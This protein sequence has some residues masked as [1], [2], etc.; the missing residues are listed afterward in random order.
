MLKPNPEA[1]KIVVH[2]KRM[3]TITL[4]DLPQQQREN[5]PAVS[6]WGV[7]VSALYWC[8]GRRT[9]RTSSG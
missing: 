1:E 9:W 7:P 8:D 4:D 2:R 3:D 6:F 5:W